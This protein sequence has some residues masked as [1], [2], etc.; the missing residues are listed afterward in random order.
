MLQSAAAQLANSCSPQLRA[1]NGHV[2]SYVIHL[3]ELTAPVV[4][5]CQLQRQAQG[6]GT[7]RGE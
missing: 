1:R 3:S 2:P 4:V 7:V 5:Q 6:A